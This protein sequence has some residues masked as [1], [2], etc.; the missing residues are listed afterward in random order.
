MLKIKDFLESKETFLK[1]LNI[2][3]S[4]GDM[5]KVGQNFVAGGS[6]SNTIYHLLHGGKLTINDIDVYH[7]VKNKNA[8][9]DEKHNWYPS[10]YVKEEG[11][12]IVD[13]S[14]GRTFVADNGARISVLR[15]SR[16]GIFNDID[17]CYEEGWGGNKNTKSKELVILEGFDLNCCKSGLDM[18]NGKIIY[19]PEFVEFLKTKQ[20]QVVNPCAPIQTTIRLFKKL[21]D[22]DGI[23]CD[24]NQEIRFLTVASKH[25]SGSQITKIIG[26]ETKTKYDKLKHIVEKYFVLRE[27]KNSDEVPYNLR[28]KY[29]KGNER[30]PE[31]QIWVYDAV[32]DFDIIESAGSINNL[33]RVWELL[34]TY[35]KKSEQDKINKIFYKNV[36]LGD[37]TEDTWS[38]RKYKDSKDSDWLFEQKEYVEVPY[39][40][41][42]RFTHMMI[43][44]KKGYHKCDFSLRH[45]DYLDK[46]TKEHYGLSTV[47]RHCDTLS[48]S[49]KMARFIQSLANK[50]GDWIIGLLEN[51]NLSKQD[52]D[53]RMTKEF[54]LKVIEREKVINSVDLAKKI[55]LSNFEHKNCVKE[56]ITTIELRIEGKKMGHCVGGYSHS[57]SSGESRIFHIDCDGIGST[58]EIGL[59]KTE[60]YHKNK[61]GKTV[62]GK[63]IEFYQ[64][65]A[66]SKVTDAYDSTNIN[67][68]QNNCIAVFEDGT[69]NIIPTS[70]LRYRIKQHQGR[71]PEKGNLEP[72]ET[73]KK[74]VTK[75]L[76]YLNQYHIPENISIN[77]AKQEDCGIFV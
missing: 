46:I 61:E 69:T 42:N 10:V 50:D 12:E 28:D 22:L 60:F 43:L 37:M 7:E 52:F 27:P 11:L 15:H 6:V 53:G 59:P 47:L 41:S 57:I 20:M 35:K 67:H 2:L 8:T 64:P 40:N 9:S 76:G 65:K 33:K 58:V 24:T 25:I 13:D 18:V 4:R 23:F 32:L 56:L 30:N 71:Y 45:V 16:K 14:Y 26:P 3:N 72:T 63:A 38:Y 77:F 68:N 29:F 49:Y 19:T 36:F 34:Y 17:Y 21:E 73:N 51:I 74:I 31:I 66:W 75:L 54:I 48:E 70:N 1:V 44:T 39:Y 55:D 62:Y 5:S